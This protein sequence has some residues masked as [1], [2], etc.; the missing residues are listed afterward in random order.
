MMIL[1]SNG[2]SSQA[3]LTEARS[4]IAPGGRAALVTTASVGY[5]ENDK[6]VPRLLEELSSLGLAVTCFDIELEN[7]DLLLAYDVVVLMGGNPFYLLHQIRLQ[8]AEAVLSAI[9][10][11]GVLIG[12]SAGSA[13]LQKSIA[14]I[15]QYSPEMNAEVQLAD[16]TGLG[17]TDAEI[18]PHYRR[19]LSRF[20][21]FEERAQAYEKANTCTITRL[22]DGEALFLTPEHSYK[23]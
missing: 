22:D 5:K 13:V 3:L 15:A 16:L 23:I 4:Y 12:I 20:D 7:P 11:R 19:F 2:L 8:K 14:L 17:L 1:T 18:L 10:A 9:A 6:H 21:Q